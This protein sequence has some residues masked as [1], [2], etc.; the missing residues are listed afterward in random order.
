MNLEELL[1]IHY[2]VV[3]DFGGVQ[4]VANDSQLL[5]AINKLS[6]SAQGPLGSATYFIRDIIK[7]HPFIDGNKRT[8]ITAAA[9][10]LS[11]NNYILTCS[12]KTLESFAIDVA[13]N[14]D[15]GPNQIIDWL[16]ANTVKSNLA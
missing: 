12:P 3:K 14:Q 10:F 9:I 15:C 1:Y 5:S 8:A 11:R 16:K 4:G 6:N 2:R 13:S 7:S